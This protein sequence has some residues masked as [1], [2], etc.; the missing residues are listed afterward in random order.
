[1]LVYEIRRVSG[2]GTYP[3]MLPS[4]TYKHCL[5]P[6]LS[7]SKRHAECSPRMGA[8]HGYGRSI[9]RDSEPRSLL[10]GHG[11]IEEARQP[12]TKLVRRTYSLP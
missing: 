1:M 4:G 6:I 5:Y 9:N 2:W 3:E 7:E 12:S 10:P 11:I 8:F